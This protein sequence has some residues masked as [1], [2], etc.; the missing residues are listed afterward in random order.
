MNT[1]FVMMA[2]DSSS[3]LSTMPAAQFFHQN[4]SKKIYVAPHDA[5]RAVLPFYDA[6]LM[7]HDYP[8]Q[9]RGDWND[10]HGLSF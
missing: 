6:F 1:L 9:D 5:Y 3:L 7:A 10:L 2:D 8:L 4:V